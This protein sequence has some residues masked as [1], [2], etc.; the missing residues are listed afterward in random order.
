MPNPL[1][2]SF[3]P[4]DDNAQQGPRRGQLE[5]SGGSDLAT[6]FKILNLHLPRFFGSKS[7]APQ[8]LLNGQGSAGIGGGFNPQSAVFEALLHAIGG[9]SSGL[10]SIY[11]GATGGDGYSA[12]RSEAPR[13][14]PGATGGSERQGIYDGPDLQ[15]SGMAGEPRS[16]DPFSGDSLLARRRY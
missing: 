2:I 8:S 10:S 16:T 15:Q 1:G 3:I 4:N 9:G 14:I 11:G 12:P 13:A 7:I 5:G 6:A